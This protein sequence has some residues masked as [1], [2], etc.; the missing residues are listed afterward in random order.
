MEIDPLRYG[1]IV[2]IKEGHVVYIHIPM[3][4]MRV[5][6]GG[7]HGHLAGHYMV[8]NASGEEEQ[9]V[10]CAG[11]DEENKGSRLRFYQLID[12]I[13]LPVGKAKLDK[14]GWRKI[15]RGG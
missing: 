1:D 2:E 6:V 11:I 10:Y 15:R 8:Y 12:N 9:L 14:S 3:G 7:A 5:K 4:Q 13:I